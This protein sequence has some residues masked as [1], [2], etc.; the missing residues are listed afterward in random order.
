M[1]IVKFME[2]E[3]CVHNLNVV[4]ALSLSLSLCLR[5]DA[6]PVSEKSQTIDNVQRKSAYGC[7]YNS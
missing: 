7:K 1:W 3:K 2:Y 5:T 6:R 4:V